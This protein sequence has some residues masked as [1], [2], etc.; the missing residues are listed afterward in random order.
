M[1]RLG[2]DSLGS[3][4]FVCAWTSSCTAHYCCA[5]HEGEAGSWFQALSAPTASHPGQWGRPVHG[6]AVST[7]SLGLSGRAAGGRGFEP[8]EALGFIRSEIHHGASLVTG[9]ARAQGLYRR[10]PL[11]FGIVVY[12]IPCAN[13]PE[14]AGG[15]KPHNTHFPVCCEHCYCMGVDSASPVWLEQV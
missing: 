12:N 9:L 3:A 14:L 11:F 15:V 5:C 13:Q 7:D 1:P 10:S 6:P 4:G 8:Q 2:S